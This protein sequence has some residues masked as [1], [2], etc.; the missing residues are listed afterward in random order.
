[1]KYKLG[2][3]D[4]II[5][6]FNS[7]SQ[8]QDKANYKLSRLSTT[9]SSINTK[10]A[11]QV[12]ALRSQ[13]YLFSSDM[14]WLGIWD[15][16]SG[17]YRGFVNVGASSSG[18]MTVAGETGQVFL[19]AENGNKIF[20]IDPYLPGTTGAF[21]FDSV[22][23]FAVSPGGQRIF[24]SQNNSSIL[25]E[26]D[27]YSGKTIRNFNLPG[28]GLH[29]TIF[30]EAHMIY[31]S[32]AGTKAVYSV[33]YLAGEVVK[34]FDL[35]DDAVKMA[36]F[37]FGNKFGLLV[38]SGSGDT[39]ALTKWDKSSDT[40]STVQLAN[41]GEIVVNP[42]TG[43]NYVASLNSIV[44]RSLDGTVLKTV[45][46]GDTASQLTLT[47]DGVH[48]IAVVSPG[49][50]ALVVDTITGV[51]STGPAAL[52]PPTQQAAELLLAHAQFGF[53]SN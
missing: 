33:Q 2:R 39:A 5:S 16:A 14:G 23:S 34:V 3:V 30:P 51:V 19:L 36:P 46:L 45:D 35:P 41:A 18:K 11:N 50:D 31:F 10:V 25:T 29:L 6:A 49:K 52:Y 24:V 27:A 26:V 7:I 43:Q 22:A 48:L 40:T 53:A 47:A 1:V 13:V 37:K 32:V 42:F 15:I 17:S 9:V 4:D 8:K 38:L 28:T 12:E 44:F 21:Q 20:I